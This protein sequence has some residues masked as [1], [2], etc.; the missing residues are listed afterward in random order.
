M[1]CVGL[2]KWKSSVS[3]KVPVSVIVPQ[4]PA[5]KGSKLR[6]V[7]RARAREDGSGHGSAL[8]MIVSQL[9]S[10]KVGVCTCFV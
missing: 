10:Q 4:P 9:S 2:N 8:R 5:R 3:A 7:A 6:D 1:S